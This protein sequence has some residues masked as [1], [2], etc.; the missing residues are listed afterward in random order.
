MSFFFKYIQTSIA[1][2][3]TGKVQ[4]SY[5]LFAALWKSKYFNILEKIYKSLKNQW[6]NDQSRAVVQADKAA[7][8]KS[9]LSEGYGHM[10]P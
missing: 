1:D 9:Y 2:D 7:A 10:N 3:S 6:G 4:N 8:G 5:F